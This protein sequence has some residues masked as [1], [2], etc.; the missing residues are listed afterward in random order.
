MKFFYSSP[1]MNNYKTHLVYIEYDE[2]K[3]LTIEYKDKNTFS[4]MLK[5][6]SNDLPNNYKEIL[7]LPTLKN[8]KSKIIDAIFTY[9]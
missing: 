9:I 4:G 3:L 7:K 5:E 6:T 2:T 8:L 1:E